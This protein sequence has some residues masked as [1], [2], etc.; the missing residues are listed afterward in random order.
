MYL[1]SSEIKPEQ[2]TLFTIIIVVILFVEQQIIRSSKE[3]LLHFIQMV[4]F[5]GNNIIYK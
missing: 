2:E 5:A 3:Y 4:T 1:D